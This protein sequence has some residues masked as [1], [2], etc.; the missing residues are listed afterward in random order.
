MLYVLTEMFLLFLAPLSLSFAKSTSYT[1]PTSD[2]FSIEGEPDETW[3]VSLLIVVTFR[4]SSELRQ[5][6]VPVVC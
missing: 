3:A 2:L 1:T 6:E 5:E 4:F